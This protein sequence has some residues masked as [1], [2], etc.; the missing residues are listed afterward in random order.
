[1]YVA[2]MLRGY[3]VNVSK[4]TEIIIHSDLVLAKAENGYLFI[5]LPIDDGIW[6]ERADQVLTDL[7]QTY[8][9]YGSGGK[10]ELWV[11]GTVS[12]RAQEGLKRLG[13]MWIENLDRKIE[14]MD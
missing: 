2:E 9:P 13:I 10:F 11:T 4:L 14:F 1:M 12:P 6:T 3:Q 7:V 5:P 8:K